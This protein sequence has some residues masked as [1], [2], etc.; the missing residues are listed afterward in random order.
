MKIK[1]VLLAV[2][3]SRSLPGAPESCDWVMW[4]VM[5]WV[6]WWV[7]WWIM[8]TFRQEE[9]RE[10]RKR[11]R[12]RRRKEN[13]QLKRSLSRLLITVGWYQCTYCIAPCKIE[14]KTKFSEGCIVLWKVSKGHCPNKSKEH[15][16]IRVQ[17]ISA[18][19]H[20]LMSWPLVFLSDLYNDPCS[21]YSWPLPFCV[22]PVMSS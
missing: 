22:I 9:K 2:A 21:L 18:N 8:K 3:Q 13:V 1:R 10:K 14:I 5:W 6:T 4:W 12:R 17:D 16:P 15:C 20:D 19:G 7:T 11:K